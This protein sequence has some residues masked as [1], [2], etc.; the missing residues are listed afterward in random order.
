MLKGGEHLTFTPLSLPHLGQITYGYLLGIRAGV[1]GWLDGQLSTARQS[2]KKCK[3][4]GALQ[5]TPMVK[6]RCFLQQG[7]G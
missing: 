1:A 3:T 2:L 5:S 6:V 4:E 7:G